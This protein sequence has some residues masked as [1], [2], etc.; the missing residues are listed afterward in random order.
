MAYALKQRNNTPLGIRFVLMIVAD[1]CMIYCHIFFT[2]KRYTACYK[3]PN[4]G[5]IKISSTTAEGDKS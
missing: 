4:C 1:R 3:S 2:T 5:R